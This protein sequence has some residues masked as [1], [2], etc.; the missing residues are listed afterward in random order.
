MAHHQKIGAHGID[1][2]GRIKNRFAFGNGRRRHRHVHDVS[3]QAL[4]RNLKGALCAGGS[5][6]KQINLG[7]PLQNGVALLRFVILSYIGLRKIEQGFD[8]K[9]GNIINRQQVLAFEKRA[10]A[11]WRCH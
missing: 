5:F 7:L 1:R 4:A 11:G 6:K 10:S 9:G 8:F 2:H 3:S